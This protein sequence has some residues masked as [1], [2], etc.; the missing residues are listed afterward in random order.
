M[1][2][3]RSVAIWSILITQIWTPVLAQTL[4]IA[5]DKS[6]AGARP[7]VGVSNG[8]P[9]VNIAPPSA[10]GVSNNRYTQFNVGP[11]GVVLNN[12]G[13]GSQTQL[14]GQV[15]GNPMLGN[16]RA[17]AILNQVTAPNPS[18]LMGM[19]EVAGNRANVIVANP[20]GITCNGCGFLNADRATLT[21]GRPV[22]GADG[23]LSFD[24]AAG[25]LG[26]EG[27]GLYG[28]NLSQL[29]LLARTLEINAQV[30][31]D[32]LTVVAGASRVGYD[33]L[34]VS[35][36]TGD[37]AAPRVAL[38]V[39]ALG[40]MYANSIR[41]IGTE[42]GVGVNVGGN[43]AALTG[44]L[45]LSANGDV[46]IQPSGRLQAATA[47]SVDS[48][49]QVSNAGTVAAGAGL[50]LRADGNVVNS[51]GMSAAGNV[52]IN[53][54]QLNNSGNVTAGLQAD[55]SISPLGA[56]NAQVDAL[57]NPG[58]LVAGGNVNVMAGAMNLSGGKLVAGNALTLDAS[59]NISNRGG[60]VYGGSVALRAAGVDN[61]SGKIT[62][63]GALT[64]NVA[65]A[66]DNRGGTVAATQAVDLR[67]QSFGNTA[68]G[69]VSGDNVAL[70]A[71]G[72]INNQGGTLQ[73][74]GKLDVNSAG[75]LNNQDGNLLGGAAEI[76]AGSLNNQNGVVQA[77]GKLDVASVGVLINQ[78]GGFYGGSADIKMA[79]LA[80]TGGKI[81][82][83]DA[84]NLTATG[85]IGNVGGTVAAQG[86]VTLNAQSLAN[87]RGIVAGN[88]ITLK[89]LGALDNSAGLIQADDVLA[90]TAASVNNRD[91]LANSASGALGLMGKQVTLNAAAVDNQAGRIGAGQDL[92]VTTG[93]L[94]NNSGNVSSNVNAKLAVGNL[95][96]TSGALTAGASLELTTGNLDNTGKIHSGQHL[97]I[98]ADTLTNRAGGEIIAAG[99]NFL[100]VG[101][102]LANAGLIDG[103]YTR[104]DAGNVTNTGRIYGDRVGIKTPTLLNDANAVIAS[105]GD[106]D[107]GVGSLVNREHALIYSAGDLRIGGALDVTGK[108][109]GLAQSIVN[110][111]ATIEVAGNA[112][113]AAA[114][115]QNLNQHFTSEVVEVSRGPKLYYRL[116]NSTELLDGSKLWLCDQV[117]ALCGRDPVT[118]LDDDAERRLLLPSTKYPESIYGPPFDY[119]ASRRGEAGFSAPIPLAYMPGPV[120]GSEGCGSGEYGKFCM[121]EPEVYRYS[122]EARIWAIFEVAQPS[123]PLPEWVPL[124]APCST[125]ASCAAEKERRDAFDLELS[126]FKNAHRA[127]NEKIRAFNA[128]FNSR[129]VANFFYYQVDEVISESRTLSTDPAKIIVGGNAKFTG[130]VTNDKS[131]IIAGGVLSVDGPAVNNMGAE[132]Q[133]TLERVGYQVRTIT[134]GG[135]R[136]E[137]RTDYTDVVAPERI[138]LAV[139]SSTGNTAPPATG[140]QKPGS[141]AVAGALAPAK[142]IEIGLPGKGIVRVVTLPP[143]IPQSALFQVLHRP[144]APYLIATDAQFL[145]QRPVLSSDYLLQQLN[146]NPGHILKRLGDGFYE[147]K[148]VAEQVM[149][150]TGQRFVGD[151]T[152]NE[153]QYKALLTAGADFA[154]KFGLTIGTALTE[155]QMLHL[156]SD[157]VWM[158]EQTVTLPDGTQQTVLSPQVYLAV[159]PGDLRG[160]G[161]LIA[162]RDT[163]IKT[164]GDV[165][166]TGTIGARNALLVEAE[167]VRN[168]VG[169]MQGKTVNLA[170]RNDID[171]LA[172]LLKGDSVTLAAGRDINLTESTQSNA[173]GGVSSTRVDGVARIDAGSLNA[174]AGRDFNAQ[175]AAISATADARVQAGRDI[176]LTTAEDRYA[177][178]Y[179]YGKKNRAEMRSSTDVG[180]Q[181]AAGGNLTLIAGQDV[182]AI[183]AQVSS[184]KQLAVGAGRDINVLAGDSAG[185]AYNETYF[186]QKGFLSSKTTHLKN[187][188]EL[189]QAVGSTFGGDSVV[190]MAGR[191]MTVVGSNV[192]GDNDVQ[193]AV[194]RDLQVLAAEE[195][196]RDY[197]YEKVKK[198]GMGGGGFSIGYNKQERI[199]WMKSASGGYTSST[200]GSAGG[201]LIIDAGRDVG[202]MGSNLLAQDGN[203]AITGRNVAIVAAVGDAQQHEYHEFK[204]SGLT[205][206]VAGGVLGAT[207]QIHGTLKQA[208]DAKDGRLA[209]VKVG[210]AAY[211]AVQTDRMLDAANGKDASAAQKEAASAQIQISVG[212]SKSVSE[213]KRTQETAFGSSV[214]AGGNVSII[215]L[216]ENGV[217]G[218]GNLSIIGSDLAGKN[219]LLAATNDLMLLSQAQTSTEVSTNKNSGWKAGVGI[220][221]SDSGSGG[222]INIFASGYMGSGNANGNGTTYRETQVSARDN[223]TL[224]SG[225]DTLLEGAQARAD[226]IRADIGRN[227][228]VVSQQD[229]DRYDAKQKQVNAGGSFSFGSM[230]GSAY[231]G[232]S[233]GKTKSNYDS[234]IEQTG[235]YAGSGGF[236][237]Y[238]GKH[239]QLDGAVIASDADAAKNLLS[240]ETF[241]YTDLKNKADYKSTTVGINLGMSGAFDVANKG[242]AL[243]SGPSGLS[244]GSTSGSES[245]TTHAAVAEG[246][247][248]VRADKETGHDSLAGLSRDTAGANGSIGKIFDKDKVREQLEFQQAF[249]QLGM[250]IAG[251]IT[252]KLAKDNPDVWGEGKP[253]KIAVHSIVAAAGAALG[254]GDVAGAIAGTVAG[255][256]ISSTMKDA[257]DEAM[258]NLPAS[259]QREAANVVLNA[260]SGAVGGLVGGGSG[261][262]GA[263]SADMFNRQLHPDEKVLANRIA[264]DAK[265]RGVDVTAEQIEAQMRRMDAVLPNGEMY[266]GVPDVL[267]GEGGITDDGAIFKKVGQTQDGQTIYMDFPV[268][269]DA[270][271]Q[272]L[273]VS[274][275]SGL[276]V[277]TGYFYTPESNRENYWANFGSPSSAVKAPSA[278]SRHCVTGECAAYMMRFATAADYQDLRNSNA[279]VL[280]KLATANGRFGA[281]TGTLGLAPGP[282]S[283]PFL[284][285]SKGA[286]ISGWLLGGLEQAIRPNAAAYWKGGA[287]DTAVTV[288][289]SAAPNGAILFNEIGEYLKVKYAK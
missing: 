195:T 234:V 177:E 118:F 53:G 136:K 84:L 104:I 214:M 174:Q 88:G 201:D 189:T 78:G 103:G 180:T 254:G 5:V 253:G 42:A 233:M 252:K 95:Q 99:N 67:A 52:G 66:I 38:D 259:I 220:G 153:S 13:G 158:V 55:G 230:T 247:I 109:A 36:L 60:A 106:M 199:D 284:A 107:L 69:V 221:V 159:Q 120:A 162:G 75:A 145:G 51:G 288:V 45:Q 44:T 146:Q 126:A 164:A 272:S 235:L 217:A 277:P 187:E 283:A 262:G 244:F 287:I 93:T 267:Y 80:N 34:N 43:L 115:I 27:Q 192:I 21:T 236:D 129:L 208:A 181:I 169:S 101:G 14:A 19:L 140:N 114:S 186:K 240:T 257:I 280:A 250:Q 113:I 273:I 289:S 239:T 40:G 2:K 202:V 152:D 123:G 8:V 117:T 193:I 56:L 59:G 132:G 138:E 248:E 150:A 139:A 278:M 91:T 279:D 124:D 6:V 147:Q 11:S 245:G 241:G 165:T 211:Q 83:G 155:E 271:L 209:A 87:T 198:S 74:N 133:R 243:G 63:G 171:N 90:L 205:I 20:A 121:L 92:G 32:R 178:S 166:N 238:V 172:G 47:L 249:G 61:A 210:Q 154:G 7:I 190:M 79:S 161:T 194:G 3:L 281:I 54:R 265:A 282:Y 200:I 176:N 18:Q 71:S 264:A 73:A 144:D 184:D 206:G 111:S 35:A 16:Q 207:Q 17:M 141:T 89:T 48:K 50:D 39:A 251:D 185:Y 156:T 1:S 270:R 285:A 142:I 10:G 269:G 175:A 58:T 72:G 286:A 131:R 28:A 191:D 218:T 98:N 86:L 160:D 258:S 97:T 196:Y 130:A 102:T 232:A 203:I 242:K 223:L 9:V 65:G 266:V 110:V 85:H 219:V 268:A 276:E 216:G 82:S 149:L 229:S 167:N 33:G 188:T 135:G 183:A 246:T 105:R 212:S 15:A 255:N 94:N 231:I 182:N 260:L 22:I 76:R 57:L 62:S 112:D 4:P 30:W 41:L 100:N 25:R 274:Y 116:E 119:V 170:A 227:L 127:L 96:N 168:T 64:G 128:D 222:G 151:Y 163:R 157:I 256:L 125:I 197:Q 49:G 225:R 70:Q 46:S 148:L 31:A 12:S 263:L 237:I 122:Q 68:G 228:T 261:A 77:D 179:D 81:V 224:I 23:M 29:D 143:V 226:S 275:T 26:I 137:N 37:G 173:S 108:A 204:Q 134:S 213:T 215:A 24:I